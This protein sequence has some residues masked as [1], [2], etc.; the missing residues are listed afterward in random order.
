MWEPLQRRK[1]NGAE[2]P[3]VLSPINRL[4]HKAGP[5]KAGCLR[6]L[7][8]NR[9]IRMRDAV[10]GI[11]V[12]QV[13]LVLGHLCL[14]QADEGGDDHQV[15]RGHA[16]RG[17]TVHGDDARALF[18]TQRVRD[19]AFAVADVP[20]V[21]LLVLADTRGIEQVAVDGDRTFVVQLGVSHRGPV[22]LALEH[23]EVHG[24]LWS[25]AVTKTPILTEGCPLRRMGFLCRCALWGTALR[26]ASPRS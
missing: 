4:P 1:A 12:D 15:A 26:N 9:M 3:Q 24:G 23:V 7:L 19:E 6:S 10:V 14:G 25:L 13:W 20:G 18:R 8:R 11:D 2:M 16:A 22:D 17:A 21:D 5:H